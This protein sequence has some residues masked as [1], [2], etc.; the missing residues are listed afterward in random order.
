MD[1]GLFFQ[2]IKFAPQLK[3]LQVGNTL[4]LVSYLSTNLCECNGS[5]DLILDTSIDDLSTNTNLKIKKY[6]DDF[7]LVARTYE[8]IVVCDIFD[9]VDDLSYLLDSCYHSL[10]NSANIILLCKKDT[11]I[12]YNIKN[13][14]DNIGYRAINDIDISN[15]YYIITARKLHM[16]GN[17]L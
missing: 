10:E 9:K 17:G 12:L 13:E 5:L 16:W 2:L 3:V 7:E 14:L 1:Y 11:N 15:N 6:S 8:Y 4:D